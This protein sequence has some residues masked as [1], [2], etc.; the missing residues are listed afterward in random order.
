MLRLIERY[1]VR[2]VIY[3]DVEVIKNDDRVVVERESKLVV[4]MFS[5]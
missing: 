2:W 4:K 3:I 5:E 1:G